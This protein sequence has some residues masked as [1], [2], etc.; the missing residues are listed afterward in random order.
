MKVLWSSINVLTLLLNAQIAF[1]KLYIAKLAEHNSFC[2]NSYFKKY[3]YQY[4]QFHSFS[5]IEMRQCVCCLWENFR[6]SWTINECF[7][8]SDFFHIYGAQSATK[9]NQIS[10][11]T[12]VHALIALL[13][14]FHALLPV[15]FERSVDIY[16]KYCIAQLTPR[17]AKTDI[18]SKQIYVDANHQPVRKDPQFNLKTLVSVRRQ[19]FC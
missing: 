12:Y 18:F 4:W 3:W 2:P 9:R 1:A 10:C 7:T 8:L 11:K 5:A 16:W 15:T 14:C 17:N 19:I 6:K 13:S